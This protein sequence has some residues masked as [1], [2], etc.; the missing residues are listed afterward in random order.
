MK[1][2]SE[3]KKKKLKRIQEYDKNSLL[4]VYKLHNPADFMI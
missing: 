3:K 1:Y 4:V 2:I